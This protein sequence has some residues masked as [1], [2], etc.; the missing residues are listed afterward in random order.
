MWWLKR[1]VKLLINRKKQCDFCCAYMNVSG[2]F[3]EMGAGVACSNCAWSLYSELKEILNAS[4]AKK[5]AVQKP[6]DGKGSNV[7]MLHDLSK[8]RSKDPSG[9]K[10]RDNDT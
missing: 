10:G 2:T 7:S 1:K 8:R 4:A 5:D 9:G 3:L 6:N